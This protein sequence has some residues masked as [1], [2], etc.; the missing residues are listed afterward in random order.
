MDGTVVT[1]GVL[2]AEARA[3]APCTADMVWVLAVR[4]TVGITERPSHK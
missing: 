3:T 1:M 2:T 4:V